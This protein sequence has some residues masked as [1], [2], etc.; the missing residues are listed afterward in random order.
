[1]DMQLQ[2]RELTYT[3]DLALRV[4]SPIAS[5]PWSSLLH[6]GFAEHPHNRFDIVVSDP[7]VTLETRKQTTTIKE[8]NGAVKRSQ[9]D[10]FT[11]IQST[12]EQFNFHPEHN[13]SLP[14]LGG[15]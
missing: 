2:Q 10:P 15:A 1:M 9:K 3:P 13:E 7:A 12:L 6:S 8:K 5:L 11:L 4:F 14:F